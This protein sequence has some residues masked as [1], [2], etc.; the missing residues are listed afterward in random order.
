MLNGTEQIDLNFVP[1]MTVKEFKENDDMY[2]LDGTKNSSVCLKNNDFLICFQEDA[3]CT[4]IQ[5]EAPT[6]IKK[7]IFKI[8]I[9]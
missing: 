2:L 3:H 6:A 1:N 5:V 8:K 9:N 4:G 7:A